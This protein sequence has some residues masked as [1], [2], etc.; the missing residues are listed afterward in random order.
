LNPTWRFP[1]EYKQHAFGSPIEW[2]PEPIIESV[3]LHPGADSSYAEAV[4]EVLKTWAPSTQVFVQ[5]SKFP[6]WT[7]HLD[8]LRNRLPKSVAGLRPS[9]DP[10][11]SVFSCA[12]TG[13]TD[14]TRQMIDN[15]IDSADFM[16]VSPCP[17]M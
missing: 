16:C 5:W 10:V 13:R 17:A 1:T 6:T 15:A 9:N 12:A 14:P 7:E 4:T 3:V 11:V 8:A 2:D